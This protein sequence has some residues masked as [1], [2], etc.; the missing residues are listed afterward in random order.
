MNASIEAPGARP[1]R[2][3]SIGL[4]HGH[5]NQIFLPLEGVGSIF[6]APLKE[7]ISDL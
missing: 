3:G 4:P 7:K 1:E 2:A 5:R 6:P